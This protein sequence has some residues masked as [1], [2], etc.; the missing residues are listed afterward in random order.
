MTVPLTGEPATLLNRT[1]RRLPKGTGTA[2]VP[3]VL[4]IDGDVL[5]RV[6]RKGSIASG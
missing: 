4:A 5:E 2:G 1:G 6:E 3:A